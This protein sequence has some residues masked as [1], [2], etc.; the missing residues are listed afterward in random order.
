MSIFAPYTQYHNV[1]NTL[2]K[3]PQE[4]FPMIAVHLKILIC[5]MMD[6]EKDC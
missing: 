1:P 4:D 5:E 2:Q 3:I 6:F